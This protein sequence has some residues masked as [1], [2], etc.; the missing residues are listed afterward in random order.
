MGIF[1]CFAAASVAVRA[2]ASLLHLPSFRSSSFVH[3]ARWRHVSNA[4]TELGTK[5]TPPFTTQPSSP[6]AVLDAVPE[7]LRADVRK[8]KLVTN[9][10]EGQVAE[11]VAALQEML[12]DGRQ[13]PAA[14]PGELAERVRAKKK[15]IQARL[16]AA[17]ARFELYSVTLHTVRDG[18]P[19]TLL[20]S[21]P[22]SRGFN[23]ASQP[24][25]VTVS[26]VKILS[27]AARQPFQPR[28]LPADCHTLPLPLT[29]IPPPAS[30]PPKNF[31]YFHV[32]ARRTSVPPTCR[33]CRP[34][35]R[36]PRRTWACWT[37]S[38]RRWPAWWRA[39]CLGGRRRWMRRRHRRA[40]GAQSGVWLRVCASSV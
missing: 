22:P 26:S 2:F 9:E 13:G 40:P 24:P 5:L 38:R 7:A 20:T 4:A 6:Q 16:Q 37:S 27:P 34:T 18:C 8:H 17:T 10:L 3:L 35:R 14:A 19:A 30:A 12:V 33:S 29:C 25:V 31:R 1:V 15:A 36:A 23:R 11:D 39:P 28:L 32:P 21:A